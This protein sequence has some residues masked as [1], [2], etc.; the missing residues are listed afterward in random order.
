MACSQAIHCQ[1]PST[2]IP[3]YMKEFK[4][5]GSKPKVKKTVNVHVLPG[6]GYYAYFGYGDVPSGRVSIFTILV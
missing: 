1:F 4:L 6:G 2:N 3:E 5:F